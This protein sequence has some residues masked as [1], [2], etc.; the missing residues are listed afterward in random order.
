MTQLTKDYRFCR[1]QNSSDLY[2]DTLNG[3][4]LS[5]QRIN[6]ILITAFKQNGFY[7]ISSLRMRH[8]NLQEEIIMTDDKPA[9]S[10]TIVSMRT[11][12]IHFIDMIKI[13]D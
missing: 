1:G 5:V 9:D 11:H 4:K 8:Q 3:D 2:I 7:V 10:N 6:H 12:S 13:D